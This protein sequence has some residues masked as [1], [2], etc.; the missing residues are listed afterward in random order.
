MDR[1]RDVFFETVKG[2]YRPLVAW[3]LHRRARVMVFDFEEDLTRIAWSRRAIHEGRLN[4]VYIK[5]R[6]KADRLAIDATEWL[7]A[8]FSEH[9]LVKILGGIF[10]KAEADA[11]FKRGLLDAVY[12]YLFMQV[13]L[14]EEHQQAAREGRVMF[15]PH[16][17]WTWELLLKEWLKERG[18]SCEGLACPWWVWAWSRLAHRISGC[19]FSLSVCATLLSHACAIA[20][21][22]LFRR[23]DPS[24]RVYDHVYALDQPFQVKFQGPR[25]FDFLLDHARLTKANTAFFVHPSAEG[26]WMKAALGEG[27]QLIRASAFADVWHPLTHL[28]QPPRTVQVRPALQAAWHLARHPAMPAWL[29]HTAGRGVVTYLTRSRFLEQTRFVNYIYLM[30]QDGVMQRWWNALLR[31]AGR[32]SWSFAFSISGGYLYPEDSHFSGPRRVR[33]YQ[34]ADHFIASSRRM[35]IYQQQQRPFVR[36]YHHVGNVWSELIV[37]AQDTGQAAGLRGQWFGDRAGAGKVVAWFDTSFVQADRSPSTYTEGIAGYADLLRLL[38]EDE[39]LLA[40]IKPSKDAFYC[41]DP[42]SQWSHPLG[43]QL[44][45]MWARLKQHPRI[46]FAG[47]DADPAL[48]IAASDLVVTLCF[49]SPTAEALGAR[50]RAIWYDPGQ[51]WRDTL[52]GQEPLLV[53][54]GFDELKRVSQTLLR[55]MSEPAYQQFL[56]ERVRGLVE[57]HL[58]GRGLSRFRALLVEAA[59]AAHGTEAGP[60]QDGQAG[61]MSEQGEP[62]P[63]HDGARA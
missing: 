56:D 31:R 55:E 16:Q 48:V 63:A 20:L 4:R 49:S 2:W 28:R 58:D 33:T 51:R 40:V 9:R 39:R 57:D 50:K 43:K 52:Y 45:D 11:V 10:G 53:A 32:Q 18:A 7:F 1:T 47:D 27:H 21:G 17:G 61:S 41:S 36:Q 44:L 60:A 59:Q 6:P 8:R 25:R 34:N 37:Q 30:V 19:A 3:Y 38:E 62:E 35:I 14:R 42:R 15:V 5:A 13:F 12:R 46:Y 22:R 26:A 24:V 29:A 23:A 54:H